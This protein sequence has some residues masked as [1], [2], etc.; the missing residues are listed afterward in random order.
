MTATLKNHTV[1][2]AGA[3]DG[4]GAATAE[5]AAAAGAT[6]ILLGR[7]VRKL[8][9]VY[10]RINKMESAVEPAIYPLD[11]LQAGPE[12]FRELAAVID[13]HF[14]RLDS[15]LLTA[16]LPGDTTPLDSY[17]PENWLQVMHANLTAPFAMLQALYPL[18]L[19]TAQQ[20]GQ[21]NVLYCTDQQLAQGQA[22]RPAYS[23]SKAGLQSFM[24]SF[25]QEVEH[26]NGLYVNGIDPGAVNTATRRKM[27]PGA[28]NDLLPS[29]ADTAI[30]LL[31]LLI[32]NSQHGQCFEIK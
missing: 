8:E 13:T 9:L 23:A 20:Q 30:K 32:Q 10:D 31:P 2:I 29:A 17:N 5:A 7:T 18:L 16:A 24:Q 22:F 21:A 4:L 6:V 19:N 15:L 14:G 12:Q 25:A 11:L 26:H 27:Y 28:N 3:G 1:L